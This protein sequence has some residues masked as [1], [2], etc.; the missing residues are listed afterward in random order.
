MRKM[1]MLFS[2]GAIALLIL[3]VVAGAAPM[4]RAEE[5]TSPGEIVFL[6]LQIDSAR[7]T[8]LDTRTV[9]GS[10]KIPR[11]DRVYRAVY[12][13]AADK[14]GKVVYQGSID[15]PL[16]KRLE[17]EDPDNP[18]KLKSKTV[19]LDNAELTVRIPGNMNIESVSFYRLGAGSDIASKK[20]MGR[21]IGSVPV[22]LGAGGDR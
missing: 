1:M 7:V 15:D 2:M 21:L 20:E 3:I 6:H 8:L 13:E 12:F 22:T 16:V 14:S 18:G 11:G 19:I 17:Y 5:N 10:L 9:A 4:L